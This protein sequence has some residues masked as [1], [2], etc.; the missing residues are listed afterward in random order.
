MIILIFSL[1]FSKRFMLIA[2]SASIM[3]TQILVWIIKPQVSITIDSVD[4][5]VRIGIYCIAIIFAF[6]INKVFISKIKENTEQINYQRL[7]S[8]ISSDY[9]TVN[10]DNLNQA[11]KKALKLIG[12]FFGVDH[13][14]VYLLDTNEEKFVLTSSWNNEKIN[15]SMPCDLTVS[16][17]PWL[18]NKINHNSMIY[19][20]D[21]QRLSKDESYEIYR[22]TMQQI[23]TFLALPIVN[24]GVVL[25][26][27]SF[28]VIKSQR[29]FLD[30]QLNVLLIITNILADAIERVVPGKRDQYN[31]VLRSSY[32]AAQSDIV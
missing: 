21:M 11:N 12:S 29:N 14:C 1:I 26:F 30:S 2:I 24:N 16:E 5:V 7:I 27:L 31:G 4:H 19:A 23:K 15:P 10:Q 28:E 3:I 22:M 8:E 6:F 20:P 25:G 17:Y 13:A 32:Q 9:V 18:I